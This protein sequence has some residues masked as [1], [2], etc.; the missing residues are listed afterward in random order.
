[1]GFRPSRP[2]ERRG[3]R[4]KGTPNKF[5]QALK[6]SILQAADEAHPG[7]RVGYLTWLA[8]ENTTAFAGLLGKVLPLQITGDSNDPL[9]VVHTHRLDVSGLSDEQLEV[10]ERALASTVLTI[11]LGPDGS[12]ALPDPPLTPITSTYQERTEEP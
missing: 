1:M 8:R 2:G 10:L 12:I 3:G 4:K 5:S 7:G 11:D 9:R 6:E